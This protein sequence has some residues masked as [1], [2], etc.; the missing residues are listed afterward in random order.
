MKYV[1]AIGRNPGEEL[2]HSHL[3]AVDEKNNYKPMCIY[4]WNR[5][6][7]QAF[8]IF[9]GHRGAKGLCKICEK[10]ALAGLPPITGNS[11]HKTKWL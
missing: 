11:I 3:Y 2:Q 5:S 1:E 10:R 8:S 4:G 9:R 7:G 6:D